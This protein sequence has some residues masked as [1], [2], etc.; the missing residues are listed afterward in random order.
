MVAPPSRLPLIRCYFNERCLDSVFESPYA[1][2]EG[3]QR[4]FEL[5]K[6]LKKRTWSNSSAKDEQGV[7]F[8]NLSRL[9]DRPITQTGETFHQL[10]K[11]MDEVQRKAWR[12][13]VDKSGDC[14]AL[15]S[16]KFLDGSEALGLTYAHEQ[17]SLAVSLLTSDR[18]SVAKI[19]LDCGTM[20]DQLASPSHIGDVA[21]WFE[22]QLGD[23]NEFLEM[24]QPDEASYKQAS[25]YKKH[26]MGKTNEERAQNAKQ[27]NGQ[28]FAFLRGNHFSDEKIS[29]LEREAIYSLREGSSYARLERHSASTFYIY[30]EAQE[31]IGYLGDSGVESR[32]IRVDWCNGEVHS[33]PRKWS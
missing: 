12:V 2:I 31:N 11:R 10:C 16:A 28:Y 23:F 25:V 8:F 18:W 15:V 21:A 24:V 5:H 6:G 27:G 33:H 22:K 13:L 3:L 26:V 1:A 4:L 19:P 14:E 17:D 20:V 30:Y 7:A 9:R 29:G 32:Q